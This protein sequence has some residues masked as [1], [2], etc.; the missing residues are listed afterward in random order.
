[1]V[2]IRVSPEIFSIF[3]KFHCFTPKKYRKTCL[4]PYLGICW[5]QGVEIWYGECLLEHLDNFSIFSKIHCFTPKQEIFPLFPLFPINTYKYKFITI[6]LIHIKSQFPN[7]TL[8]IFLQTLP[9]NLQGPQTCAC[10]IKLFNQFN[11]YNASAL[12]YKSFAVPNS[13]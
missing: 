9:G 10:S 7:K 8:H 11:Y 3:S 12:L 2:L 1:M 6:S 4:Q 5:D 13:Y